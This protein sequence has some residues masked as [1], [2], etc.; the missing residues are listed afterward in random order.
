MPR[1]GRRPRS[2]A[3]SGRR[4]RCSQSPTRRRSQARCLPRGAHARPRG[5]DAPTPAKKTRGCDEA[6]A[7]PTVTSCLRRRRAAAAAVGAQA[8]AH[9]HAQGMAAPRGR[10]VWTTTM[11]ALLDRLAARGRRGGDMRCRWRWRRLGA[12]A[13][14]GTS[15]RAARTLGSSVEW[16][17]ATPTALPPDAR[18]PPCR[19]G[20]GARRHARALA[21]GGRRADARCAPLAREGA[22]AV[23]RRRPAP[24]G[25]DAS[26]VGGA[27][28][29]GRAREPGAGAGA[30]RPR[31]RLVEARRPS[32]GEAAAESSAAMLVAGPER[33]A[34]AR[35]GCARA[36]GRLAMGGAPIGS[37]AHLE[38]Q[39]S[40]L[41]PN[42]L[43]KRNAPLLRVVGARAER[44]ARF[45]PAARARPSA[46]R[47]R[48]VV[49]GRRR[50]CTRHLVDPR[51]SPRRVRLAAA[52][53]AP[54]GLRCTRI[55]C[56]A[57]AAR[58]R[59]RR[60]AGPGGRYPAARGV[61]ARRR[62]CRR[63]LETLTAASGGAGGA[64]SRVTC[65]LF[66]LRK[67]RLARNRAPRRS[68]PAIGRAANHGASRLDALIAQRGRAPRRPDARCAISRRWAPAWTR[69]GSRLANV[70]R[71][72]AP[73]SEAWRG[74]A[75]PPRRRARAAPAADRD[76]LRDENRPP[77]APPMRSR[78]RSTAAV[79][80]R[81][82]LPR[83]GRPPLLGAAPSV[84][85]PSRASAI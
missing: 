77:R 73:P 5:A 52:R 65:S 43:R 82:L 23:N 29:A 55:A 28:A 79:A 3:Q 34:R 41:A 56:C 67:T 54:H 33:S 68:V 35:G 64:P 36:I 15:G 78:A 39:A 70:R 25:L 50:W 32:L 13:P 10:V 26:A 1:H 38:D 58:G 40:P 66:T 42:A 4:Q 7:A 63:N 75:L 11:F 51:R 31:R 83:R 12:G 85:R 30:D 24:R 48:V 21:G 53:R 57:R 81:G 59:R 69:T 14:R 37:G 72:R 49:A 17:R 18:R 22:A 44:G 27:R 20:G 76:L 8:R 60:V 9:G 47:D 46:E 6:R 2:A 80:A 45:R 19:S 16:R 74:A 61:L 62:H 71:R 84:R